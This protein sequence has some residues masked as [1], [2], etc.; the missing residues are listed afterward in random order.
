[1]KTKL[2]KSLLVLFA[3]L[4]LSGIAKAQRLVYDPVSDANLKALEATIASNQA[5]QMGELTS[6][7]TQTAAT[8]SSVANTLTILRNMENF[9]LKVSAVL[10]T[11]IY[12]KNIIAREKEILRMQKELSNA[13]QTMKHLTPEELLIWNTN[14]LIAVRTTAEF[15]T[16]AHDLLTSSVFKMDDNARMSQFF[17]IDKQLAIQQSI[18]KSYFIQYSIINEERA[19]L[20]ALRK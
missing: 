12:V 7:A 2:T 20:N 17:E 3:L 19:V 5:A 16:L 18:M 15:I 11:T 14:I 10:T 8:A 13:V 9:L 4:F 6:T 1:M